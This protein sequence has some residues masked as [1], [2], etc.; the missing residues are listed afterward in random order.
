MFHAS[1]LESRKNDEAVLGK[2]IRNVGIV[3]QPMQGRSYLFEDH[4]QLCYL[5]RIRFPMI[6]C[7]D[8]FS[9][10]MFHLLQLA[11]HEREQVST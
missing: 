1:V 11:C 4:I 8:A 9:V 7:K 2:R 5:L 3:F 10:L 6:S